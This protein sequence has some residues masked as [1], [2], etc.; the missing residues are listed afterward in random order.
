ME[1]NEMLTAVAPEGGKKRGRKPTGIIKKRRTIRLH[2][3]LWGL[4]CSDAEEANV[5]PA[6]FLNR[7]LETEAVY[8]WEEGWSIPEYSWQFYVGHD[9]E[10]TATS[11]ISLYLLKETE[12]ALCALSEND[13]E[14]IAHVVSALVLEHYQNRLEIAEKKQTKE[15]KKS[16]VSP[17]RRRNGRIHRTLWGY[18]AKEARLKGIR[19]GTVVNQII[20]EEAERFVTEN[21]ELPS[22]VEKYFPNHGH[23]K[24]ASKDISFYLSDDTQFSIIVLGMR[25][26]IPERELFT[27]L[28]VYHFREELGIETEPSEEMHPAFRKLSSFRYEYSED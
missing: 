25:F 2:K 19:P 12:E 6:T 13:K 10:K 8:A 11:P 27:A 15:K 9:H 1:L 17:K 21:L 23:T 4:L 22:N 16:A 24:T 5:R 18:V 28:V 14:P 3:E 26:M 7:L 20:E